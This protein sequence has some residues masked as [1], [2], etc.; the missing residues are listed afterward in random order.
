MLELLDKIQKAQ[1]RMSKKNAH[2]LL[3]MQ[4]E[5][6]LIQLANNVGELSKVQKECPESADAS[7]TEIRN[8]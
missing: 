3:L 2:R 7:A 5:D 8:A 6:A 1:Q 4:C